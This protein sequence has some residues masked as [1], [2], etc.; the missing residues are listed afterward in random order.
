MYHYRKTWKNYSS[1]KSAD[2]KQDSCNF[3][4]DKTQNEIVSENDTMFVVVNRTSYDIFEGRKVLDHLM[5]IP[6]KHH[7]TIQTFSDQE[8]VDMMTIAGEYEVNG[9]DIFARAATSVARSVAHQHTHMIKMV[10]KIPNVI[11]YTRKP[12]VLLDV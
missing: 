5:V 8:K 9:Y 7:T 6:K 10:D 2:K 11:I 12:Y 3:C 4:S 1:K